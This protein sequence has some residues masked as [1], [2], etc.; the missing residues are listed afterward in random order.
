MDSELDR[1]EQLKKE[2]LE[3]PGKKVKGCK[4]CKKKAEVTAPL[5]KLIIEEV[6]PTE[7][8][9]VEAYKLMKANAK[10]DKDL[11]KIYKIFEY[12]MGYDYKKACGGCGNKEFIKFEY[13]IK[14]N[15]KID[16]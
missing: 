13:T 4:S 9:I 7:E 11:A 6:L 16:I 8:E 10:S 5:P 2:A 14:H 1:L 12:V 15:L 3:N